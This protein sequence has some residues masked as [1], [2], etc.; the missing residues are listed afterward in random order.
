VFARY[1]EL[2]VEGVS[3][4]SERTVFLAR[5]NR[6]LMHVLDEKGVERLSP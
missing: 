2:S 3:V 1:A 6:V 5:G 4:W